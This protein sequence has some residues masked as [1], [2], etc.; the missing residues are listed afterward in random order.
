MTDLA[1]PA[2]HDP[3]VLHSDSNEVLF[4]PKPGLQ[5]APYTVF[6][7]MVKVPHHHH[8]HN[9]HKI[10]P[11]FSLTP[12]SP[13]YRNIGWL[14]TSLTPVYPSAYI[15][16]T[17]IG[18]DYPIT[19][20]KAKDP[21]DLWFGSVADGQQIASS[22]ARCG[23]YHFTVDADRGADHDVEFG[24]DPIIIITVPPL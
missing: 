17:F 10:E 20:L 22:I 4:L 6:V 12:T 23:E 3:V 21:A 2:A 24:V 19:Q 16:F 8:R 11:R 9:H 1:Q 15:E 5:T 14:L 7:Q 13:L 18:S